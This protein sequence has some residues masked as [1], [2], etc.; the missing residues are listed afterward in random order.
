MKKRLDKQEKKYYIIYRMKEREKEKE[1][2]RKE[3]RYLLYYFFENT[4]EVY[5]TNSISDLL[6]WKEFYR[7]L[8]LSTFAKEVN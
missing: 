8:D 7:N 6:W 2:R 3:M 1:K 5:Q 4:W